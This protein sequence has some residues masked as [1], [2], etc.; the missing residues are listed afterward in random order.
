MERT[1]YLNENDDIQIRRD[2]PSIWIKQKGKAGRRIPQNLVDRVVIIGNVKLDTG[3]ITLFTA[4]GVPVTFL[5]MAGEELAV[6][7]PYSHYFPDHHEAQRLILSSEK[8]MKRYMTWFYAAKRRIQIESAM[9][10]VKNKNLI[11]EKG[12]RERDYRNII[13]GL[14]NTKSEG[15]RITR[16]TVATILREMIIKSLIDAGLDPHIGI[17]HSRQNFGLALDISDIM[18]PE[19][20][21]QTLQFIKSSR[22]KEFW[23]KK[24]DGISLKK[25]GMK[26]IIH[27]FENRR[28][29]NH[30]KIETIVDGLFDVM[31]EQ[32]K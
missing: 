9:R 13:K 21:M 23:D 22:S 5:N 7:M 24:E 6:T 11:Q 4:K 25:E 28:K 31:K 17:V 32:R 29:Y 1:L 10:L 3:V 15:W 14:V 19:V 20:D 27:R 16:R 26:D 30:Y 2:G 18:G 12:L 8:S